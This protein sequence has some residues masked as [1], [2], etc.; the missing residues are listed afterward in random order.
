MHLPL[1]ERESYVRTT[2]QIGNGCSLGG[3]DLLMGN[4]QY[5]CGLIGILSVVVAI[6][7]ECIIKP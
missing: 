2:S 1:K 7:I 6:D 5:L 4:E 3:M